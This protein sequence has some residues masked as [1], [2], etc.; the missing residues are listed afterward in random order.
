MCR[1]E[2]ALIRLLVERLPPHASLPGWARPAE[3]RGLSH[4]L[5]LVGGDGLQKRVRRLV[6]WGHP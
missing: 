4:P 1:W 2:W 3:R 5:P 6:A